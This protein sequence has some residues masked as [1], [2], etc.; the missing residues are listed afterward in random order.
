M[1]SA[2]AQWVPHPHPSCLQPQLSSNLQLPSA[3]LIWLLLYLP[4]CSSFPHPFYV[5]L[6]LQQLSL[7]LSLLPSLY[8]G[9]LIR[10]SPICILNFCL[11]FLWL[12]NPGINLVYGLHHAAYLSCIAGELMW[13][14]LCDLSPKQ[15]APGSEVWW[16][17]T[18]WHRS[19]HCRSSALH[20]EDASPSQHS[21]C[22]LFWVRL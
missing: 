12:F 2:L 8:P 21:F 19:T 20:P 4:C 13:P 1:P 16:E 5:Y 18:L 11:S 22:L 9:L 7:S 3:E 14:H 10:A 15:S 6:T 17:K